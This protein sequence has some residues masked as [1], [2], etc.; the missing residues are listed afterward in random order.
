[1]KATRLIRVGLIRAARVVRERA[2]ASAGRKVAG[3]PR[4]VRAASAALLT[5]ASALAFAPSAHAETPDHVAGGRYGD[6]TV[7]KP[8]G[9]MRGFVVLFSEA[10]GW[11]PSDQQAAD[12]LARH[13]ALVVGVDTARYAAKLTAATR[14]NCHKLY[15]DAEAIG[16]QLERQ[17][18]SNRYYSPIVAGT[19]EGAVSVDADKTLDARF[20]PCPADPALSRGPGLPGFLAK[21]VTRAANSAAGSAIPATTTGAH[22]VTQETFAPGMTK[23]ARLVALTEPHLRAEVQSEEDVSDLP[24]VELPAAHPSD[25]L[26]VVI[27]G[28]GG[29][30]DLDKTIAEAMQRQGVSLVGWDS[31]RYFWREKTPAQTSHDLAR[32]LKTYSARWH[33]RQIALVGYSFGADVMPFAYNRLPEALRAKVSFVSLLGFAPDADFQIRVTGWLGMPASDKA[34][35]VSP[36]LA[37]MPPAIVQCVYGEREPD[38]LCPSLAGKGIELVRTPGDHHFG[39]NYDALAKRIVD[40]W[41]KQIGLRG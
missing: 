20:A 24:L 3:S 19:G 25:M 1:M 29:W 28:D 7:T 12:A 33:T 31:L 40:S 32:V 18:E 13:G 37:K 21:G 41:K 38:S 6:V 27:S 5:F 30:R 22:Q 10:S 9:D 39:G 36:E 11:V 35:P 14:E 17:V 26:A 15:G 8:A 4:L 23:A 2:S 34:L 16:H